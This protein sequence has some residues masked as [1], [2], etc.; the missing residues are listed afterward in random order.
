MLETHD[1]RALFVFGV[2]ST[3]GA[4]AATTTGHC[5]VLGC[6]L[7]AEPV[8]A[9]IYPAHASWFR[10]WEGGREGEGGGRKRSWVGW[11]VPGRRRRAKVR[12]VAL[13]NTHLSI[14]RSFLLVRPNERIGA[15]VKAG[16]C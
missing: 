6:C 4:A 9:F 8:L 2:P 14:M 11:Q 12:T 3:E 10:R 7:V 5:E 1:P 15:T 13:R 16:A